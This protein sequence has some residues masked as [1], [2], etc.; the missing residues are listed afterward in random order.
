MIEPR[1]SPAHPLPPPSQS[2]AWLGRVSKAVSAK[3]K[4]HCK[5]CD[6][7]GCYLFQDTWIMCPC[8]NPKLYDRSKF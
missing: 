5:N 8:T 1:K 4:A 2:Q 6:G 3:A 7:R